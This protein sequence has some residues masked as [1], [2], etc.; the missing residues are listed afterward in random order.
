MKIYFD[1]NM[2]GKDLSNQYGISEDYKVF[3]YAFKED[4]KH[5][6]ALFMVKFQL[7]NM[8]VKDNIKFSRLPML[9]LIH[10]RGFQSKYWLCDE[11]T[12][13]CIGIYRWK[14]MED[15]K[16]YSKSIAMKFMMKR[17]VPGSVSF[18]IKKIGG[19]EL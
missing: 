3:R 13:T 18:Q 17:S 7:K 5:A 15:A 16:K 4:Y 1:K 9:L 6:E 14:T 8:N 10:F 11:K 19:N 12:N 2:V